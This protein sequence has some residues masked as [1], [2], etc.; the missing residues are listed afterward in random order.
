[1][2]KLNEIL[3]NWNNLSDEDSLE[4]NIIQTSDVK[5]SFIKYDMFNLDDDTDCEDLKQAIRGLRTLCWYY[6]EETDEW[7][8]SNDYI[9]PFDDQIKGWIYSYWGKGTEE[10]LGPLLLNSPSENELNTWKQKDYPQNLIPDGYW[11]FLKEKYEELKK[12]CSNNELSECS[13]YCD[14]LSSVTFTFK[15]D[16][17]LEI[18]G[19]VDAGDFYGFFC[20]NDYTEINK[21]EDNWSYNYLFQIKKHP[22]YLV[23]MSTPKDTRNPI[24]VNF[25]SYGIPIR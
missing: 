24:F 5:E 25:L 21:S 20:N 2:K 9:Y 3:I 18:S 17:L 11:E 16:P 23:A 10:S 14:L 4:N 1:M 22:C 19:D 15:N 8:D 12:T 7:E 13:S 6:N